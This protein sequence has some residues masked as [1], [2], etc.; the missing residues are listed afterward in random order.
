MG[1]RLREGESKNRETLLVIIN[2]NPGERHSFR[3]GGGREG[4]K[5]LLDCG[6][7]LKVES[8]GFPD[9]GGM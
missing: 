9:E 7:I 1:N 5:K 2:K 4:V 6:Y 8:R 3:P